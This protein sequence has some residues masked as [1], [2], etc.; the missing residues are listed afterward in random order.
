MPTIEFMGKLISCSEGA[1]LRETL[2]HHDLAPHNGSA[3][4][5][6]CFGLGTCGTCAVQIEGP[7]S[8]MSRA[9]KARL[10]LPPFCDGSQLRLSCQVKVIGNIK[11]EKGEGFWGQMI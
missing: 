11:V 10:S 9:E 7:V 4:K 6:N 5:L 3:R 8:K 1:N 2:M